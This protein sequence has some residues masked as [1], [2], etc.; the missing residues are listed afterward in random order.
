VSGDPSGSPPPGSGARY[1][2]WLY[3]PA[4]ARTGIAALF[5]IEHEIM[6]GARARLDHSVAHA[7]LA[8]WQEETQRL[9]ASIP[10]H[11]AAQ[12]LRNACLAAG[13]PAP[14]L[15]ALPE[16]AARELA[17]H[18]LGRGPATAEDAAQDAALWTDGL[19]SPYAALAA[20][21]AGIGSYAAALGR[22]L[23]EH[24]HMATD[25]SRSALEAQLRALPGHLTPALRGGIVW[26]S[27]ALRPPRAA[28]D[29]RE[30]LAQNWI[31]W[32][33]ARRAMRGRT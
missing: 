11:P 4:G 20:G 17:R 18:S 32:R 27:L 12:A 33:A 10:A 29:R 25:R 14:D 15:C 21:G 23:H 8:W 19:F 2:A 30:A 26:A 24:E 22:A 7:R 1:F 31:A 9:R 16:L 6:T 28:A 13:L 3:A 5:S